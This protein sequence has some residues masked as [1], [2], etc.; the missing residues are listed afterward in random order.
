M[1]PLL[2]E[3]SQLPQNVLPDA[4]RARAKQ[5]LADEEAWSRAWFTALSTLEPLPPPHEHDLSLMSQLSPFVVGYRCETVLTAFALEMGSRTT[6]RQALAFSVVA[7][8]HAR[9]EPLSVSEII[10]RGPQDS[11][12]KALLEG[13]RENY[14]SLKAQRLLVES[15][16]PVDERLVLLRLSETGRALFEKVCRRLVE[17]L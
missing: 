3:A 12:R 7:L 2:F 1:Q 11:N 14:L 15:R 17:P 5:A 10:A 9:G 8:A 13:F 6:I 16:S 4:L